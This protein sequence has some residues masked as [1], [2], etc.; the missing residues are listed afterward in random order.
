MNLTTRRDNGLKM[1]IRDITESSE[2]YRKPNSNDTLRE[3]LSVMLK[4]IEKFENNG[5]SMSKNSRDKIEILKNL[6]NDMIKDE[7][8]RRTIKGEN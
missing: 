2:K 5:N 7:D 3:I 1:K 6:I 8:Q 4:T